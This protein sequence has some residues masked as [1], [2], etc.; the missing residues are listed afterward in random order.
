[1]VF[2]PESL[3]RRTLAKEIGIDERGIEGG[4]VNPFY[5]Y[6]LWEGGLSQYR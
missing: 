5:F 2:I 4:K 1:M 6:Y 3:F